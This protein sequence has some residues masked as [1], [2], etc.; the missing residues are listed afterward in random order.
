MGN[1]FNILIKHVSFS[2]CYFKLEVRDRPPG[3]RVACAA[4]REL[5]PLWCWG[6]CVPESGGGT[7]GCFQ[8]KIVFL[9][10][11]LSED[12]VAAPSTHVPVPSDLAK[13]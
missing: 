12:G 13:K 3:H 9:G 10:P 8:R 2:H 11:R 1:I 4:S 7:P 5:S 6:A